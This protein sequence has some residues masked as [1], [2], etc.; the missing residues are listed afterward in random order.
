MAKVKKKKAP[1]TSKKTKKPVK[2]TTIKAVARQEKPNKEFLSSAL[3]EIEQQLEMLKS[4]KKQMERELYLLAL[5]F[6]DTQNQENQLRDRI[7]K[8]ILKES[9]LNTHKTKVES[10]MKNVEEKINKVTRI[11]SEMKGME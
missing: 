11:D 1:K 4:H 9:Q 7:S 10:E 3:R 6:N 2:V 5:D 8:L